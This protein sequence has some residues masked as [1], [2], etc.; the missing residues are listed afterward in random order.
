MT[1]CIVLWH[2]VVMTRRVKI[3]VIGAM[4]KTNIV[5]EAH[6]LRLCTSVGNMRSNAL[7]LSCVETT[8]VLC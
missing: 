5:L 3:P 7:S 4:S 1:T 8:T 2:A 6:V